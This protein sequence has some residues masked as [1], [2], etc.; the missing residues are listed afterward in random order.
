MPHVNS[1]T[2]PN[3]QFSLGLI[4]SHRMQFVIRAMHICAHTFLKAL[5]Q[6]LQFTFCSNNKANILDRPLYL[7]KNVG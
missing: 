4:L 3:F 2:F 1:V 6:L 5:L 7:L